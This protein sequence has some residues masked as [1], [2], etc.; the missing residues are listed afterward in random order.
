[1]DQE[2]WQTLKAI[3][4]TAAE[5]DTGARA[6]YIENACAGDAAMRAEVESLLE[7]HAIDDGFI[8]QPAAEFS[9]GSSMSAKRASWIGRR[10]SS[11]RIVGE[12]GRGGMSDVYKA[13]RDDDEYQKEVAVKVLRSGYANTSLMDRFKIEKQILATLDHPNIA[14]LLDG[15]STQEG[16]P[17]LVMDYICGQPIDEYC[18][19]NDLSINQR[20]ELFR[21]LCTAVQYVH[22]H[23]MVHGD[24]KCSNVLV[25]EG[26]VVKLLDFGIAKLLNPNPDM[27]SHDGKLT[28]VL[29]LTPEYASPEQIRGGPITTASDV[30]SLGIVLF[31]LLTGV[32][33][34]TASHNFSYELAAQICETEPPLPSVAASENE[35][36]RRAGLPSELS[37]D[38]D[39]IVL[40]A[41][42][43]DP[44]KRYSSV[45]Q[46][47]ED[48]RRY[49][50]GFPVAARAASVPYKVAKFLRRHKAG[51]A[52]TSLLI[53][54]LVGGI[55]ATSREA[56][57]AGVER[58]RAERHF[59]DVR[60]L[61]NT[62]MFDV[63]GAIENLPG[64]TAARQMLVT[65]S[66]AYL[67]GLSAESTNNAGLQ[68]ELAT[69]YEKI[70][71]IQGGFRQANLGDAPHAVESYRKAASI[72][73]ALITDDPSGQ[74]VR[75]E[76]LRNYGKLSELLSGIGDQPAAIE[77]S[78]H[79]LDQAQALV[80][81]PNA[82]KA[83]RRNLGNAIGSLGWL[84]ARS[85]EVDRGLLLINESIETYQTLL[86]ADSHDLATRRNLAL[87]YGRAG[88]IL[89]SSTQRFQEA[90][91]M[92]EKDYELIRRMRDEDRSNADLRKI[93]GFALIGLGDAQGRI[94]DSHTALEMHL[95]AVST[96]RPLFAA[97]PKNDEARFD[98]G[99][100]L[101]QTGELLFA[102][103]D[104]PAAQGHLQEA[105][106][107][108]S[109]SAGA[110]A[111]ALSRAQ[112]ALG[113]D[114]FRLGQISTSRALDPKSRGVDKIRSCQTARQWFERS[115]PILS[116][117]DRDAQWHSAI[118]GRAGMIASELHR[119]KAA[120]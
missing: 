59:E 69:A 14:K 6:E 29:A 37:G 31:R 99:Y 54:T 47:S 33:P 64:S 118:E 17:Y 68:R 56:H 13:V 107:I 5:C 93:E 46:L 113:I 104:L 2:R 35:V 67:D 39:N 45:E 18:T 3:F 88:E 71:D 62:F 40:M 114:Y 4:W 61:A 44:A 86:E 50:Q 43:K 36:L 63:E 51:L 101:G 96:L 65:N 92:Y 42:Q 30:Y 19:R 27:R 15:G 11:Y 10:L 72:R 98:L 110:D 84:L 100:A 82:T 49:L 85:G 108:L 48:L 9:L 90:V 20:L 105:I 80:V 94:G 81:A 58:A 73:G 109:L 32:L 111:S 97:D 75:R 22:Q 79:L 87:A 119:C 7:A 70:A 74:D 23:L 76:L 24:L 26:G 16:L 78:R 25:A 66:L 120:R 21:T 95:G 1:M 77:T 116:A 91:R 28:S 12:I 8:E 106:E 34:H 89:L 53:L 41:M 38:I 102:L 52:A 83:D 103:R 117:A 55:V 60:R 112:V 115:A 57:I